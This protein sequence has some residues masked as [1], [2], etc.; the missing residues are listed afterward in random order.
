MLFSPVFAQEPAPPAPTEYE[1]LA[2][3][4]VGASGEEVDTTTAGPYI[5]GLFRLAIAIAGGLAVLMIIVGGIEYMSTDAF[6]GKDSA[7]NRIS[8]A[9]WGLLLAISAWLILFT[10]NPQLVQFNLSIPTRPIS[11]T[12]AAPIGSVPTG[13]GVA[14]QNDADFRA[15]L[16]GV[17]WNG[18]NCTQVGQL[19]C[20]SAYGMSSIVINGV[21]NLRAA[22]GNCSITITGGTEYWRHG[23]E[24]PDLN[25]N[26]TQHRPGGNVVDLRIRDAVELNNH[27]RDNGVRSYNPGCASG[28]EKYVLNGDIYVNEG[29]HWHVCF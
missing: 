13:A 26:N 5:A 8:N 6:S 18:D 4:P 3:L 28:D 17:G 23:N 20:T 1:L 12:P 9:I 2:P 21:N 14:W 10:I 25:R 29:T 7:K 22:C 15:R 27:I 11:V 19:N 24:L 16:P